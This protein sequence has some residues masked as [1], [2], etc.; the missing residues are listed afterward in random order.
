[1]QVNLDEDNED[2]SKAGRTDSNIW[3][4]LVDNNQSMIE[5]D[6]SMSVVNVNDISLIDSDAAMQNAQR[7]FK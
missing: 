5:E 6:Q 4:M 1:M 3:N 7:A 2:R